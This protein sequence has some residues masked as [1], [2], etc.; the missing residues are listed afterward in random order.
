MMRLL[1]AATAVT[2]AMF[3]IVLAGNILLGGTAQTAQ[4]PET[5]SQP[6]ME[7]LSLEVAEENEPAAAEKIAIE[8]PEN[9]E[10]SAI[11]AM[12]ESAYTA[13]ASET[14]A[15]EAEA[16]ERSHVQESPPPAP[17]LSAGDEP[18]TEEALATAPARAADDTEAPEPPQGEGPV[19]LA[20][21]APDDTADQQLLG[22]G[23]PG[24]ASDHEITW[25]ETN[26][27][28]TRTP[29]QTLELVLGLTA[30]ALALATGI[31]YFVR[32]R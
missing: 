32:R 6:Q 22:S 10:E 17:E 23:A 28:G 12:E 26:G 16:A 25:P 30:A 8:V 5:M 7:A 14:E 9:T 18:E 21:P 24:Q 29:W 3:A 4:A 20:Q 2:S 13:D 11:A 27:Y 31:V 19:A 1:T 15:S